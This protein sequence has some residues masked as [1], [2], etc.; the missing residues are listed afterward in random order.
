[1]IEIERE[2]MEKNITK[3]ILLLGEANFSFTISLLKFCE[4]KFITS[5]CYESK[6][7]LSKYDSNLIEQN[8]NELLKSKIFP[9][10]EIDA[11]N[12]QSH[13]P[14]SKFD[15]II[16]M[17]PH[18]SGRSN[19][20][21]NRLL[22]DQFFNSCKHVLIDE[23]SSIFVTLAQGQGGTVFEKDP[24][25]RSNKDSWQI[26]EIAQKNGF[27][28]TDCYEFKSDDFDYYKSTGFRNQHKAFR[29]ESG[30]VHKFQLSLPLDD[31]YDLHVDH[32][33]NE[34]ERQMNIKGEFKEEDINVDLTDLKEYYEIPRL[35]YVLND[36]NVS[37]LLK[38]LFKLEDERLIFSNDSRVLKLNDGQLG[39]HT[40]KYKISALSVDTLKWSHDLSFWYDWEKFD[41]NRFIEIIRSCSTLIRWIKHIDSFEYENRRAYCFRLIYESCDKA[42]DWDSTTR[43][44]LNLRQVIGEK[45]KGIVCLR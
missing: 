29:T 24:S 37:K 11:T 31:T 8:L 4:P 40:F 9:L 13:F 17:F 25:K 36:L 43:M 32:P 10:F 38:D 1:M 7:N 14:Q 33:I 19:L 30:L 3:P 18:V 45:L 27:I 44:Q 39:A 22:L 23:N 21:K 42:L 12:L 6:Q 35:K 2:R 16:F 41:L 20:K 26:N 34:L 5:T 28:L 15:R